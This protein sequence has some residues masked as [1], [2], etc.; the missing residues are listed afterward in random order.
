M[1]RCIL[2]IVTAVYAL[3]GLK[4]QSD[5]RK[6][7]QAAFYEEAER[8][9]RDIIAYDENAPVTREKIY[10]LY[11][12]EAFIAPFR[13][14]VSAAFET[15]PQ[16]AREYAERCVYEGQILE[17]PPEGVV[18]LRACLLPFAPDQ[19]EAY[20]GI[21]KSGDFQALDDLFS[22]LEEWILACRDAYTPENGFE[23]YFSMD[24][25]D[26]VIP[27][28]EG[29]SFLTDQAVPAALGVSREHPVSPPVRD[30]RGA[31]VFEYVS[32]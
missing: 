18:F 3:S 10:R 27:V 31:V 16:T 26:G 25:N 1:N 6:V 32:G 23:P 28:A 11:M 12:R 14:A 17:N 29:V 4:Y 20:D 5:L 7:T 9:Y 8:A 30:A 22:P 24:L 21:Q 15:E 19:A 13:N 2:F